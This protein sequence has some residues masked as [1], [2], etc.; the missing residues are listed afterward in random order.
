MFP[1]HDRLEQYLNG[2][3][4]EYY[5][6]YQLKAEYLPFC[7]EGLRKSESNAIRYGLAEILQK[8]DYYPGIDLKKMTEE[9]L[10][11][12]NSIIKY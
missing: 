9:I 4:E 7:A 2:K 6:V 12:K 1:S 10:K 11:P 5:P 8:Y 3:M